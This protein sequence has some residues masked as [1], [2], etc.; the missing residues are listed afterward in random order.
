MYNMKDGMRN[1][2]LV[3]SL[4]KCQNTLRHPVCAGVYFPSTYSLYLSLSSHPTLDAFL[5]LHT[6]VTFNA[7]PLSIHSALCSVSIHLSGELGVE[8]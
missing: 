1:S 4:S 3:K 6:R 8:L 2:E 7:T 5:H